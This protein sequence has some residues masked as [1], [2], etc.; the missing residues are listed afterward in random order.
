MKKLILTL[1]IVL[2][3]IFTATAQDAK[4]DKQA[5]KVLAEYTSVAQITPDQSAKIKPMIESFIATRK[6]NKEKY[7][8]DAAGLKTANKENKEN[9]KTQLKTVLSED[10]IN[11]IE[12]YNKQKREEKR[13]SSNQE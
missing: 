2:A 3:T 12:E 13:G 9:F 10:Q 6:A 4:G 7:A 1:G 5:D 8:N 11:K